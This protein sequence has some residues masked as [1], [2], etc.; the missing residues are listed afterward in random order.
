MFNLSIG[1]TNDALNELKEGESVPGIGVLLAEL[2]VDTLLYKKCHWLRR[3]LNCNLIRQTFN[4]AS[5]R[6]LFLLSSLFAADSFC[7]KFFAYAYFT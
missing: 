6:M 1:D 3:T 2:P 4:V 7:I 5:S